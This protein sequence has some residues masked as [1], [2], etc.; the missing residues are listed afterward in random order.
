MQVM[1]TP[2]N[3]T[4]TRTYLKPIPIRDIITRKWGIPSVIS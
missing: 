1:Y 3:D 4:D 2:G